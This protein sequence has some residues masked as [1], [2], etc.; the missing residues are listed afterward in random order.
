MR[1]SGHRPLP[2]HA[3][4]PGEAESVGH[5]TQALL[6]ER[7]HV[8]QNEVPFITAVYRALL[9]ETS[10]DRTSI[11]G[12]SAGGGL[13]LGFTQT[14][15]GSGLPQPDRLILIA[16]WLDLTL[17]NPGIESVEPE[18]PMLS[19]SDL[20][21]AAHGWAGGDDP[22][23]ARLSPIH[24]PLA[25]LPVTDVYVGTRDLF[26]PDTLRLAQL[27]DA[28]GSVVRLTVCRGGVHDY[29]LVPAPEGRAAA[30]AIVRS[31]CRHGGAGRQG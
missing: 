12:D 14:L 22:S 10:P 8:G 9:T 15:A 1:G 24:G 19:R 5:L 4:P 7:F 25:P 20:L 21:D 29:P 30:R 11:A 2:P 6:E 23:L 31:V 17:T 3:S 26:Y 18:D 28:A 16:P 13:A 27:A